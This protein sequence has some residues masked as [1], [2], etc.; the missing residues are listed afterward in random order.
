VLYQ[1]SYEV[2]NIILRPERR[3]GQPSK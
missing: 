3:E 2:N 1:L